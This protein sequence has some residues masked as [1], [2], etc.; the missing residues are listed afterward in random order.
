VT[1]IVI[2]AVGIGSFLFRVVPLLALA[3]VTFSERTDRWIRHAGTAA[4]TALIAVST[5][6]QAT[7]RATVPTVLAVGTAAVLAARGSSM[8][9]LLILGGAV[10]AGGMLAADV[11]ARVA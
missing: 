5:Q 7:G 4:V 2:V 3:R 11:L 8:V 1:W 6:R 10:F 9:R